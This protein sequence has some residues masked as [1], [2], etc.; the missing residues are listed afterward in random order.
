MSS[1]ESGAVGRLGKSLLSEYR[2]E[3]LRKKAAVQNVQTR[4]QT[5]ELI[6]LADDL[7]VLFEHG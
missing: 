2:E 6:E 3:L 5:Q 1:P 4:E 7:N